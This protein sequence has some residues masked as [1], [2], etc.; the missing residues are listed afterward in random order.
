MILTLGLLAVS[1]SAQYFDSKTDAMLYQVSLVGAVNNPGIFM[2]PVSTRVSE[3]I[4]LAESEYFRADIELKKTER[5]PEEGDPIF[6]QKY[7]EYL[8]DPAAKSVIKGSRR[9]IV[10]KRKIQEFPV[11]LQKYF[12]LGIDSLNPYVMDGDVIFVPAVQSEVKIFGA[13]HKEGIYELADNDKITDILELALGCREE[14]WLEET[15]L[16]RFISNNE[17]KTIVLNL[18][19]VLSNPA[20]KENLTLQS[21]DRIFIRS[22]P[23]FRQDNFVTVAGCVDFPGLYAI[24]EGET[25]LLQILELCGLDAEKANLAKAFVQRVDADFDF[26]PEFE[27]LKLSTPAQMNYLEYAYLKQKYREMRARYS[28]DIDLLWKTRNKEND[29]VLN[30]RDFIFIPSA[31]NTVYV[32]GQ[33]GNP[34]YLAI[35]PNQNYKYYIET[36]GG[37]TR[38][39]RRSKIRIIKSDSGKWLKPDKNL[40]IEDGDVIF[41][42]EKSEH[43]LTQ[44]SKD[45]LT[46]ITQFATIILA[47]RTITLN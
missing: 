35:E 1:L 15:E 37:F 38:T 34:G 23:E 4:K 31:A 26:D 18:Q 28:L 20:S 16:V 14:A 2:V 25:T 33:V 32:S 12:T 46:I 24:K 41:I 17:T 27:R 3:V 13:V 21:G 7:K 19:N 22:I 8:F 11:D 43:E 47:I 40:V 29:I 36:A 10:L 44:T 5:I 9:N 42:P 30:N 6:I 45:I 39:A